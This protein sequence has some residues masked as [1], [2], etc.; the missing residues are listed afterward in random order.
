M[1]LR[2]SPDEISPNLNY[3]LFQ[4]CYIDHTNYLNYF[5]DPYIDL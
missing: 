5:N 1:V 2:L 3:S 4:S